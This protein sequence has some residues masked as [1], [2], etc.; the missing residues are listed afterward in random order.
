[1][2]IKFFFL[3][4]ILTNLYFAQNNEAENILNEIKN[5]LDKVEDYS[6]DVNI[7]VKMDFLKMPKSKAKLY[8]KKPDKFKFHSES[9]ALLPKTG[10]DFN[11]QRILDYEHKAEIIGDTLL[12]DEE[13]SVIKITPDADT[14]KFSSAILLVDTKESLIKELIL[15]SEMNAKITSAF[16]YYDQKE[17]ALPSE[18]KVSFDFSEV[19]ESENKKRRGSNVPENFKGDITISYSNYLINQGIDDSIFEEETEDKNEKEKTD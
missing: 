13:L 9:F 18:I 7:S 19:K 15:S 5:K 4:I 8:F 10:V 11:P 14:L 12:N 3:F 2:K 6:V 1:M 16:K 17:Y